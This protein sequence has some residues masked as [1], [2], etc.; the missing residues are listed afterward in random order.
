MRLLR[1]Y[2]IIVPALMLSPAIAS[3]EWW[4]KHVTPVPVSEGRINIDLADLPANAEGVFGV[5][6]GSGNQGGL[7]VA[8]VELRSES[9]LPTRDF[10]NFADWPT[11]LINVSGS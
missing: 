4:A 7:R 1:S 11:S 8:T 9:T 2:S 3:C 5:E 6:P 10:Q